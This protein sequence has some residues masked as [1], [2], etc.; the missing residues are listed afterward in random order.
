TRDGDQIVFTASGDDE[1]TRPVHVGDGV[2]ENGGTRRW[3]VMAD[4]RA[5]ELHVAQGGG[6]YV[7]RRV[8]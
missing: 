2:W 6:H 4:D 7:L 5:L 8:R 1:G 3:F